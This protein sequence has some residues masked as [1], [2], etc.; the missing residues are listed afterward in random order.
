MKPAVGAGGGGA[1]SLQSPGVTIKSL[2]TAKGQWQSKMLELGATATGNWLYQKN[3]GHP[4]A[5]LRLREPHKRWN[6]KKK[7]M[8]R[9]WVE[10]GHF[11]SP[12]DINCCD[13]LGPTARLDDWDKYYTDNPNARYQ[14]NVAD[15]DSVARIE[16]QREQQ[17]GKQRSRP[18]RRALPTTSRVVPPAAMLGHDGGG[19]GGG[20]GPHTKGYCDGHER[21]DVIQQRN[22]FIKQMMVHWKRMHHW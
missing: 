12:D 13:A 8:V 5:V 20:G 17:S 18:R 19:G 22:E 6:A 10:V 16:Q 11:Y 3:K 9:H 7:K 15:F 4:R 1:S 21:P 2:Q 14:W